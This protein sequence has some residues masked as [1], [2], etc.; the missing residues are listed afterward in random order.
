MTS[1]NMFSGTK[2]I[3]GVVACGAS[4]DNIALRRT[5]TTSSTLK[6]E[7][8]PETPPYR[9][10]HMARSSVSVYDQVHVCLFC[11]Q[12][13]QTQEDYRP[14]YADVLQREKKANY[15]ALV[16]QERRYWD[17]LMMM[18]KDKKEEEQEKERLEYDALHAAS[19]S[20]KADDSSEVN[21]GHDG[22]SDYR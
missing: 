16:E 18:D 14:S 20:Y 1:A 19:S 21:N 13:F 22:S 11:S 9:D 17:P 5:V 3:S 15:L 6:I 7:K 4:V 12:F 2:N 10:L 8:L